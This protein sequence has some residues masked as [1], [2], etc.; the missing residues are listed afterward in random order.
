MVGIIVTGHGN[1]AS[2]ITST[3]ELIGGKQDNYDWVDFTE[4]QD[5]E[6]LQENIK[7]KA[8]LMNECEKILILCDLDGGSPYK[9]ALLY[10]MTKDNVEVISGIN[11]P[12]LLDVSLK[13]NFEENID[14]L[15][16]QSLND[17]KDNF[18]RFDRNSF[19]G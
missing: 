18:K 7:K 2:G 6:S 13:R 11:F 10:S 9:A 19:L 5:L 1:F 15:I 16:T 4:G 3:L 12:F 8:E 14:D 17:A